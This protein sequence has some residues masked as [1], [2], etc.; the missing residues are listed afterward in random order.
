MGFNETARFELLGFELGQLSFSFFKIPRDMHFSVFLSL[1]LFALQWLIKNVLIIHLIGSLTN[2]WLYKCISIVYLQ[3]NWANWS[4]S[5][6][7][8]WFVCECINPF[9]LWVGLWYFDTLYCKLINYWCSGWKH[10]NGSILIASSFTLNR[11]YWVIMALVDTTILSLF[12]RH[13][14][15]RYSLTHNHH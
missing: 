3:G 7:I 11:S 2:M 8:K 15:Q 14:I 6:F 10:N 9:R 12:L 4:D 1:Y 13:L 5:Y